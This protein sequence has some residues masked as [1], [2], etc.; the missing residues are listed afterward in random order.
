MYIPATLYAVEAQLDRAVLSFE[1]RFEAV[2]EWRTLLRQR[3]I[4]A[5]ENAAVYVAPVEAAF[6]ANL[7]RE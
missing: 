5:G 6:G 4:L 1:W 3:I 7:A 2:S